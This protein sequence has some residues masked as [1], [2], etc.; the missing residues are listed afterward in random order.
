[1][2]L[3]HKGN[4]IKIPVDKT[5]SLE[6]QQ[7]YCDPDYS[8]EVH[9]ENERSP[10]GLLPVFRLASNVSPDEFICRWDQNSHVIDVDMY[11]AGKIFS[12][13]KDVKK[14][15][16]GHHLEKVSVDPEPRR[17][18]IDIQI[19][20][21]IIYQGFITVNINHTVDIPDLDTDIHIDYDPLNNQIIITPKE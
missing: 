11:R 5:Y 1:M 12:D 18:K 2:Y 17:F 20:Q 13:F 7:D 4:V 19:P 14:G 21:R 6:H 15:Y 9:L 8:I 3:N 10:N 16:V